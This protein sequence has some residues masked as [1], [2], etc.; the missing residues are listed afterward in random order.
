[1]SAI[2]DA[3]LACVLVML[4]L[5]NLMNSIVSGLEKQALITMSPYA[6]FASSWGALASQSIATAAVQD[7]LVEPKDRP[8]K[9]SKYSPKP[10]SESCARD[11]RR[12]RSALS[13]S[14]VRCR[15]HHKSQLMT[16]QAGPRQ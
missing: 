12:N 6:A 10:L 15:D 8:V 16:G 3:S 1:M 4:S 5:A 2:L 7:W 14:P 13:N 9:G 11:V